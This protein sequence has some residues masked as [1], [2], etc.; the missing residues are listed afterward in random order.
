LIIENQQ[1]FRIYGGTDH[2]A[3]GESDESGKTRD[4]RATPP[5]ECHMG[6]RTDRLDEPNRRSNSIVTEAHVFRA[7]ADFYP[8]AGLVARIARRQR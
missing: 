3:G 2:A 7:Y 4:Q 5:I 1:M 8:V 6:R